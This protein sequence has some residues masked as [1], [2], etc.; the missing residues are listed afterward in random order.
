MNFPYYSQLSEDIKDAIS[1][2]VAGLNLF[3]K[4]ILNIIEH[5]SHSFL[6]IKFLN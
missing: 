5:W 1:N 4:R 2:E 3:F 6:S